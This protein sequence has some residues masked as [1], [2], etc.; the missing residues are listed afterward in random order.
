MF[1][2]VSCSIL[3]SDAKEIFEM[4]SGAP[5]SLRLLQSV[6]F[7]NAKSPL[8]Q[9]SIKGQRKCDLILKKALDFESGS[10]FILQVI[11]EVSH[12]F[13]HKDIN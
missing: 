12:C 9:T 1:R 10:S 8:F 3:P 13:L 7:L 5:V 2:G 11:A 4:T 6:V